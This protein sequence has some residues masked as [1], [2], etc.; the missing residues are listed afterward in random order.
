M[1]S[2]AIGEVG[3]DYY[4]QHATKEHQERAFRGFIAIARRHQLPLLIHC[5][6]AY[7]PL[8][9]MLHQETDAL[10][11]APQPVR[12]RPHEPAYVAHTAECLAQLRGTTIDALG[13]LTSRNARRLFK[14]SKGPSS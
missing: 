11:L 1:V 8:L 13:D 4:R 7:E 10:F 14:L 5:R 12:G 9:A 3:L 6:E 2:A